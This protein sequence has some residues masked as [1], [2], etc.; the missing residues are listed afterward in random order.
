M[1]YMN[2]SDRCIVCLKE[3]ED[4][5]A[6]IKHHISYFPELI[7]YVHFDCHERIHDPEN[8]LTTFIQYEDGD[9]R[10][11]YEEKGK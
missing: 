6:L 3:P 8:P 10:K 2:K 4:N 5:F 9:S 11:F 7:A 1:E